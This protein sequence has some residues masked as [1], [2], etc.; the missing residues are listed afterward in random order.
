MGMCASQM[1]YLMLTGRKTDV[2]FQG[3]QINQ[4]RTVLAQ[5]SQDIFNR[6]LAMKAP[7]DTDFLTSQQ[8]VTASA[9]ETNFVAGMY[10]YVGS[11]GMTNYTQSGSLVQWDGKS[12]IPTNA[13]RYQDNGYVTSG[14][15]IAPNPSTN[16]PDQ[17]NDLLQLAQ[18]NY[19]HQYD[20][21]N[22]EI[23]KIE[24]M[25]R[26]LELKLKNLDTQQE[27][28]NTEMESVKKVIDKNIEQTFKT[29]Q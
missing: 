12:A 29:F 22:L 24:Q 18:Y 5:E 28:L 7:S 20:V 23:N 19:Q 9:E 8:V 4:Q 15:T 3:Q 10:Y 6:L 2:E 27:A 14:G 1:R 13:I 25:D 26:S 21:M 17:S 16:G 11:G